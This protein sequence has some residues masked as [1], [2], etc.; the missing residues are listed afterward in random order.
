MESEA[1]IINWSRKEDAR[2]LLE[3]EQAFK[4]LGV[5]AYDI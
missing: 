5:E 1:I 3:Q 2:K 4:E